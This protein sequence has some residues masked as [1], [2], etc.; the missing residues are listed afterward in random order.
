MFC[1]FSIIAITLL[2]TKIDDNKMCL[3]N[4]NFP[5]VANRYQY[6]LPVAITS[7]VTN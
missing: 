3:N 1:L 2:L 7:D 4:I 5:P 6:F